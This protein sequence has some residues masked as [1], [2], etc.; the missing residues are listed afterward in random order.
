[1]NISDKIWYQMIVSGLIH[2]M[3]LHYLGKNR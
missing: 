3:L 2:R 1:M